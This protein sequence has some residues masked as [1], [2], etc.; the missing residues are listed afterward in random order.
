MAKILDLSTFAN[1]ESATV[2]HDMSGA[3]I[4]LAFKNGTALIIAPENDAVF[5]Y[6]D[7]KD[8]VSYVG[9]LVDFGDGHHTEG[10]NRAVI[11]AAGYGEV[12][13]TNHQE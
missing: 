11:T 6:P 8:D 12:S 5:F 9:M 4:R 13:I 10:T 3:R 7:A 1:L 2:E